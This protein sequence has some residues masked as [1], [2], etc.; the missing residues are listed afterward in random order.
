MIAKIAVSAAAFA[1]DKPYSYYAGP[2]MTLEPGMRVVVPFGRGNRRCEGIVLSVE[3]GTGEGLKTVVQQLDT[4]SLIPERMLRLAAFLR[5][6]YFCT[7]Y[8]GVR[9]MLPAGFWFQTKALYRLT[10]DKSWQ[11]GPIRNQ[12]ASAVL[13]L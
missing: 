7:F 13:R 11:D 9:A 4:Q 8:D 3:P 10:E 6:R 1:I 2:E 12:T 5:E